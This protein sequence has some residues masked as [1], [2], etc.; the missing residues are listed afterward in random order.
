MSTA[1]MLPMITTPSIAQAASNSHTRPELAARF[2]DL[3]AK[4]RDMSRGEDGERANFE[5]TV[6]EKTGIA[7]H[8]FGEGHEY[9]DWYIDARNDAANERPSRDPDLEK[10]GGLSG[11][12]DDLAA[13]ILNERAV[14][15]ADLI[16]QARVCALANNSFWRDEPSIKS[17]DFGD[18]ACRLLVDRICEFA[19]GTA[20]PE[21]DVLPMPPAELAAAA[22]D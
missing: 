20:F 14:T 9:P 5:H 12:I 19:G 22:E 7:F 10:W 6:F 18:H 17:M 15:V 2:E 4:F 21:M 13:L 11:E 8:G 1:A 3:Y 16:L